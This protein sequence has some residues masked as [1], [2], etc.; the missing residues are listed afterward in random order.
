MLNVCFVI[1]S[2]PTLVSLNCWQQVIRLKSFLDVLFSLLA[3]EI[4]LVLTPEN[5]VLLSLS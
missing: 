4:S 2:S 1:T 5:T 3:D